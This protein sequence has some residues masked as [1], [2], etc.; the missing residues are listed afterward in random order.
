[1]EYMFTIT[2]IDDKMFILDC[3]IK[4]FLNTNL[5]RLQY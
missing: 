4:I 3:F 5:K 1:M 2:I